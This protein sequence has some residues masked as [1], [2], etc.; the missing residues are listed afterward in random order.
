VRPPRPRVGIEGQGNDDY[1]IQ[2]GGSVI[3][4]GG[5]IVPSDQ[6]SVA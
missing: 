4:T 6:R 3:P 1:G 2:G 5:L